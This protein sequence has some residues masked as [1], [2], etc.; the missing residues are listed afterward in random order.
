MNWNNVVK[1]MMHGMD[2][3]SAFHKEEQRMR[4]KNRED[5]ERRVRDKEEQ[6]RK[7]A[8]QVKGA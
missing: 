7:A 5:Y 8:E 1:N 2:S 6:R 4:Q 3:V